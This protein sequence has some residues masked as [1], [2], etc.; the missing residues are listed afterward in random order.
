[1]DK[2]YEK[3]EGTED[4]VAISQPVVMRTSVT[5]IQNEIQSISEEITRLEERKATL[6]AELTAIRDAEIIDNVVIPS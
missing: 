2:T 4:G 1:M 6:I 5:N 3:I